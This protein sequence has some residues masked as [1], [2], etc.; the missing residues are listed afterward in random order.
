VG[1]VD[2]L[3]CAGHGRGVLRCVGFDETFDDVCRAC[4][5]RGRFPPDGACIESRCRREPLGQRRGIVGGAAE[6]SEG[7]REGGGRRRT[8]RVRRR[9][10]IPEAAVRVDVRDH[11]VEG[12]GGDAVAVEDP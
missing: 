6:R 1:N 8:R 10:A 7:G 11:R 2:P 12:G 9:Q 3:G 4:R 5:N